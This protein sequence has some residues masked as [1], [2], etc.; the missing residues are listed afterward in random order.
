MYD[1][2]D[3]NHDSLRGT[4]T[5]YLVD[6]CVNK[7]ILYNRPNGIFCNKMSSQLETH[8]IGQLKGEGK[9]RK[10]ESKKSYNLLT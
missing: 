1:S 4:K 5:N 8:Q 7:Y 2:C 3:N 9:K 10:R 6:V